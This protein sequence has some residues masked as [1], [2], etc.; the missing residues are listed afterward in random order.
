MCATC[1]V[2]GVGGGRVRLVLSGALRLMDNETQ[3]GAGMSACC[4]VAIA[5]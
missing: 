1:D 4:C 3:V 5:M 2:G